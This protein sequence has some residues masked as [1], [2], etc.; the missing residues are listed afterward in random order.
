M[1]VSEDEIFQKQLAFIK[2]R[3]DKFKDLSII[4]GDVKQA[5]KKFENELELLAMDGSLSTYYNMEKLKEKW[6]PILL[7]VLNRL[8]VMS[9]EDKEITT[10]AFYK[11]LPC[12][13]DCIPIRKY[14]PENVTPY[15]IAILTLHY[16]QF[17][18]DKLVAD[19]EVHNIR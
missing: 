8:V 3:L 11:Q 12:A 15:E 1:L 14:L 16:Y 4:S 19:I 13:P 17:D 9:D 18:L 6:V 7:T 5:L 2:A 10:Q